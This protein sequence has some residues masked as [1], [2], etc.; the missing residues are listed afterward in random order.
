MDSPQIPPASA[1]DCL[2]T[3]HRQMEIYIDRLFAALRRAGPESVPE[4][5]AAV[6][7]IRRLSS[8]HFE[9]EEVIFYPSL[10][11]AFADLLAQMDQQHEDV[12]EVEQHIGE[13]LSDPP[14]TLEFRWLNEVR[15]FGT[16]LHD[17]IQ[18]HIVEEEDQLFR[19][20]ES[21]LT[22]EDQERLA[23]EMTKLRSRPPEAEA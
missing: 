10:R 5:Q 2:L 12:R 4:V 16:P 6:R 11:P 9:K 14:P 17:L 23:V 15:L 20:A 21:R 13:L 1:C 7:D 22:A 8:I 19:L 3:D 18:H